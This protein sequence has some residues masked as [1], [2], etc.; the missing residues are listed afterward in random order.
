[1]IPDSTTQPAASLLVPTQCPIYGY[2]DIGYRR[3]ALGRV[4]FL[5]P[6]WRALQLAEAPPVAAIKWCADITFR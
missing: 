3:I 4:G 6:S 5:G 1:M 2:A